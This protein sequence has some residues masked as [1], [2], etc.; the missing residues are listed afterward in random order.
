MSQIQKPTIKLGI[1]RHWR[2]RLYRVL[3]IVRLD[4]DISR[5][6]IGLP[7]WGVLY[8]PLYG[9]AEPTVRTVQSFLE[10]INRDGYIGLRFK[11]EVYHESNSENE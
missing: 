2:G 6:I 7:H 10:H 1:Y 8:V 11:P 5:S 9:D 3:M 4:D